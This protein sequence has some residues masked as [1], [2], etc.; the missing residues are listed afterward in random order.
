ML[1]FSE[2]GAI[3]IYPDLTKVES[4]KQHILNIQQKQIYYNNSVMLK[5]DSDGSS[6]LEK[7]FADAYN[8]SSQSFNRLCSL[9]MNLLVEYGK[10][11]LCRETFIDDVIRVNKLTAC[12]GEQSLKE[13]RNIGEKV[14]EAKR[15]ELSKY[16]PQI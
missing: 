5:Y 3:S 15:K 13:L 10:S 8:R 14:I 6:L 1:Q 2:I 16:I 4:E 11:N 12:Y 9:M 7:K